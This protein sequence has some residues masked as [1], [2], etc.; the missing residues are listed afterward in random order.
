M[1]RSKK[2]CETCG[3]F[4]GYHLVWCKEADTTKA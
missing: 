1:P 2:K 4:G 3:L